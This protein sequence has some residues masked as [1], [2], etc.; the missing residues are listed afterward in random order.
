MAAGIYPLNIDDENFSIRGCSIACMATP[1]FIGC[2][3]SCAFSSLL[4][5]TM[6]INRLFG[7]ATKFARITVTVKDVSHC[8]ERI[9]IAESSMPHI[10]NPPR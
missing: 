4:A 7:A 5:K 10:C 8:R 1:W 6:R 3:F 9:Q 2:G